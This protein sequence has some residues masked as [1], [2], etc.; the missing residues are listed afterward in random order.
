[1]R[2]IWRRGWSLLLLGGGLSLGF[3]RKVSS[4]RRRRRRLLRRRKSVRVVGLFVFRG[5]SLIW[6]FVSLF[7]FFAYC[8]HAYIRGSCSSTNPSLRSHIH[9][10]MNYSKDKKLYQYIAHRLRLFFFL[11]FFATRLFELHSS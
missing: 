6:V 8:L 11:S 4:T 5:S 10:I 2:R 3:V 7:L 1:M 9:S